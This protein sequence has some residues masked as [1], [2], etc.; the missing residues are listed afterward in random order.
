MGFPYYSTSRAASTNGSDALLATGGEIGTSIFVESFCHRDP[1][2]IG[3]R[4][5]SCWDD[6]K[7]RED[8]EKLSLAHRSKDF[9]R[10]TRRGGKEGVQV[11]DQRKCSEESIA[12]SVGEDER[13]DGHASLMVFL[14]ILCVCSS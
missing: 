8:S 1:I 7:V 3:R 4:G 10:N 12:G 5:L 11:G 6:N 9:R 14:S 2:R 13:F